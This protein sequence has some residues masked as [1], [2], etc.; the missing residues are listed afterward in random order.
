MNRVFGLKLGDNEILQVAISRKHIFFLMKISR[1][2]Q[3]DLD[4]TLKVS[5]FRT[6]SQREIGR[7][8]LIR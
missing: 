8:L 7:F 1:Y 4:F 5:I 2:P 3:N 6:C